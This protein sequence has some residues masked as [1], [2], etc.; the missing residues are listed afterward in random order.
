MPNTQTE[1]KHVIDVEQ[2]TLEQG[3]VVE[4]V[5]VIDDEEVEVETREPVH[6]PDM[7]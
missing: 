2:I 7:H 6:R 4:D 3:S 5:V 1:L